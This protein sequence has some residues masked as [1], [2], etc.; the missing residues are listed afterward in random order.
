MIKNEDALIKEGIRITD[1]AMV[2]E[3]FGSLKV[4]VSTGSYRNIKITTPED[5]V[6][7]DAFIN[8]I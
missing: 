2:M 6:I 4:H 8:N 5:M 3:R 7:A 1:D